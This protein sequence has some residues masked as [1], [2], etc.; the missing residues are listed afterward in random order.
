MK[1]I[2]ISAAAMPSG[3]RVRR[4]AVRCHHGRD[5]DRQECQ[6]RRDHAVV[7][8]RQVVRRRWHGR[9][10]RH[11]FHQG[12]EGQDRCRFCSRHRAV[13]HVSLVSEEERH[14]DER[15]QR[16][17]H[18]AGRSSAQY[19]RWQDQEQNKKFFAGDFQAFSKEAAELL[20]EIG[21]IKEIPDLTKIV[22]TRFIQ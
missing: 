4:R 2:G 20:L 5:L 13:F 16:R 12:P 10:I 1:L 9:E 22:D 6:W 8:A 18:G 17:E 15:C 14:V 3:N 19:L 11:R 21:V 7:S